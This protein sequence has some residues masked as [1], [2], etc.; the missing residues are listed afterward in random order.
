MTCLRPEEAVLSHNHKHGVKI[1]GDK[2]LGDES[3]VG[4]NRHRGKKGEK[5]VVNLVRCPNCG[6]KLSLLPPGYPMYDLQ[7]TACSFRAQVKTP[8]R[9]PKNQVLGASWDILHRVLRA[10]FM[11]PPLIINFTWGTGR[12]R[13]QIIRF[14]PFIPTRNIVPYKVNSQGNASYKSFYYTGLDE[15]PHFDLYES[16]I[17]H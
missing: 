8:S 10:G 11:I 5:Q 4:N 1:M 17:E 9:S 15:L 2:G 6:K 16:G 14:Y 3:L 7:C 13:K 12:G